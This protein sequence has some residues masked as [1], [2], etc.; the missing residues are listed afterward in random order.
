MPSSLA[1]G[2]AR[3]AEKVFLFRER[4]ANITLATDQPVQISRPGTYSS[5]HSLNAAGPDTV[6]TG[7]RVTS[8]LVHGDTNGA[9]V[10]CRLVFSTRIVGIIGGPA[11]EGIRALRDSD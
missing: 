3:S 10:Q 7:T 8:F 11:D 4:S 1:P 6:R 5:R 2:K 9:S